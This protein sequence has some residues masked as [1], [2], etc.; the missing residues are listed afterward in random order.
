MLLSGSTISILS[1]SWPRNPKRSDKFRLRKII[2]H[3]VL[4]FPQDP[5]E[6]IPFLNELK[7]YKGLYRH[8]KIDLHLKRYLKALNCLSLIPESEGDHTQECLDLVQSQRLYPDALVIYADKP[9]MLKVSE[10]LNK[11]QQDV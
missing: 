6:Y 9:V 10:L 11:A 1:S 7:R 5:K 8:F 2:L 4:F 3:N